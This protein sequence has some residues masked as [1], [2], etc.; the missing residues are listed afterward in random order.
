MISFYALLTFFIALFFIIESLILVRRISRIPIRI[1][2]NGTRGKTTTVEIL[3][4]IL[5]R[6]N[7]KTISKTTGDAPNL[8][9]PQGAP[10]R[11]FR[12]G[13]ANILEN[14]HILRKIARHQ[15]QAF[16]MECMALQPDS[17]FI[18]SHRIFRPNHI[19]IT[20]IGSDHLEI[21][22]TTRGQI[23]NTIFQCLNKNSTVFLSEDIQPEDS[24]PSRAGLSINK[25]QPASCPIRLENI[26]PEIVDTNW[27][28][29]KSVS[30]YS[31]IAPDI[32]QTVF[33][34]KWNQIDR[35][36]KTRLLR[37]NIEFWNLFSVNDTQS[38]AIFLRHISET[39]NQFRL[40]ILLL[41]LRRDRPLRTKQFAELIRQ[42]HHRQEI[43]IM[44]SG[45]YLIKRFLSKAQSDHI[46]ILTVR[47][48]AKKIQDG[49]PEAT[50][51][52]GMGNHQGTRDLL[53][54]INSLTDT[55]A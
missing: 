18:L 46:R 26:P 12:P 40:Q 30:D 8:L 41:N 27:A 14:V 19:L 15:P 45:R 13:S 36:I 52:I 55:G 29:I 17:Q 22:G 32:W 23:A 33:M 10:K 34:E 9:F 7:V 1:L 2:V 16:V 54:S 5:N 35:N 21:M 37:K 31:K 42:S 38:A 53:L 4:E 39:A 11:I 28:L 3:H 50:Q 44:G 20:N 25:I 47:D 43:W 24:L 51:I 6:A 49:F 48:V